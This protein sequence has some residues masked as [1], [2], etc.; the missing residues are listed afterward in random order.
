M[1]FYLWIPSHCGITAHAI[2]DKASKTSIDT[3]IPLINPPDLKDQLRNLLNTVWQNEQN[4]STY[5]LHYI[6]DNVHDRTKS[7]GKIYNH[8]QIIEPDTTQIHV[9]YP[10]IHLITIVSSL[11]LNLQHIPQG[12]SY[13]TRMQH[14]LPTTPAS[15]AVHSLWSGLHRWLKLTLSSNTNYTKSYYRSYPLSGI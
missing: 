8:S 5:K 7:V 14:H 12:T 4:K 15:V 2:T 13:H 10:R 1:K 9:C 3:C 6:K 11:V